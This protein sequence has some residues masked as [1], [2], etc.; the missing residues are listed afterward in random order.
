MQDWTPDDLKAKLD[1][2]EKVFLKLWKPGCGACKLSIPALERIESSDKHGLTFAQIDSDTHP[3]IL[4]ISQS[5]VLPAFFIFTD[6]EMKG[7]FLGF[8]GIAKLQ[9]FIDSSLKPA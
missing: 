6:R 5:E 9:E 2:G 7:K 4:Q 8:K 1:A 3:D